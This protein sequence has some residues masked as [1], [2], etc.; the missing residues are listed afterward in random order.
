MIECIG[1]MIGA[2]RANLTPDRN[3]QAVNLARLLEYA[4]ARKQVIRDP[5]GEKFL[6]RFSG[7]E[8]PMIEN[9]A[10]TPMIQ[11]G[12]NCAVR[13]AVLLHEFSTRQKVL[14]LLGSRAP[15]RPVF[16]TAR[17]RSAGGNRRTLRE[18]VG[19]IADRE[20]MTAAQVA[21]AGQP[22]VRARE[23]H[24]HQRGADRAIVIALIV[25]ASAPIRL[26]EPLY[27]QH[28]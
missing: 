16:L 26:S 2:G 11:G 3:C 19:H 17:E 15:G 18:N 27:L 6:S 28:S 4:V 20:Q 22:L 13:I 10:V 5:A 9:V 12:L 7:L 21:V 8:V 14:Q 23:E 1:R 25:G 24:A